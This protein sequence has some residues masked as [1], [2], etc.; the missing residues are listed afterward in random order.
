MKYER[1]VKGKFLERLNRF[2]AYVDIDGQKET[3]HVKNTGRCKELLRPGAVVYLQEFDPSARK[4]KWDLIAVEKKGRIINMDSQI[5]N[6]VVKEWLESG[7]LFRK[8]TKIQPEYTYGDSRV[9]LYVEADGKKVLIEVKGVTLEEEGR[10]RFPDAPSERAV[11]HVE[12]LKR[13]V[14][15]GYEAYIFF[16]IQ[17]KDVRY[18]TPNMDTHP[19]FG[20]A[21]REAALAGVHVIAYDCRVDC[22]HIT[23]ADE[24]KVVL[25]EPE[26][27]EI[28]EP[29]VGWFRQNKRDLPWRKDQDPYHVWVSEIMLQQTRVEA[30]KPY[31]E[32]FLKE[33]PRVKDLAE[34]KEDT[35]LKLWEGLGYYNR[36]R[37]M[38]KAAQQIMVDFHG[39]FPNTYEEILS[40]KGIGNYTAGAISA[41]AFGLPKPAVDGNVLRVV[42]RITGSRE[43]IMKQSVRKAMERALEQVIPED[44]ASDFGQGLIELGAIVC[45][46]NG[47]PKCAECPAA[48]ACVARKH[49]LTAEIPVKKKAKARRIEKRTVLIFKDGEKLA[50]RKRPGKGL[51]AGL[52]EF[53]NEEGRL[54]QKEVTAY[55]KEIGLMPVR[56]KKLES[57]KH[58]FSHVEWHMTGY[59]V[60]VD[61]LEKTNKKEFLFIHPE[62][63]GQRYPLPSAFE[64]Y[65]RYAGIQRDI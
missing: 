56:V 9:D 35:L 3:V 64:T 36:V 40:L 28:A 63:I 53:P 11:K 51:L 20:E 5:P 26:L 52:Y 30:V 47:E 27:Y 44:A 18:F 22:D 25:E 57:A 6:K 34:A 14:G 59:E 33:L 55:S 54:A 23:L 45:V 10:V 1:I 50:I 38:Q 19:A 65:I 48:F 2:I 31:Y 41:F 32:R 46:P 13:A 37:N 60:I 8:V 21:L 16:V 42:S 43:D 49:G 62:E 61:E 24:V 7:G 17:M 29:I 39:E 15:E 12:E 58:I 4:T